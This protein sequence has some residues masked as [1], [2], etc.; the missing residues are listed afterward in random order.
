MENCILFGFKKPIFYIE[1]KDIKEIIILGV[2]TRTF[3][4]MI[5]GQVDT[6]FTMISAD[7]YDGIGK[8]INYFNK[9]EGNEG[10]EDNVSNDLP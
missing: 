8:Y 1:F 4:I 2:T 3:N 10:N 5:K 9:N 7:E 6:E